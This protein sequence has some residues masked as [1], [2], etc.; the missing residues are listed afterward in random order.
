M[1]RAGYKYI[2]AVFKSRWPIKSSTR[3]VLLSLAWRADPEGLCWPG[4]GWLS[5]VNALSER[6]VQR[7]LRELEAAEVVSTTRKGSRECNP[8]NPHYTN[9]Y[10]INLIGLKRVTERWDKRK[11]ESRT[12]EEQEKFD[13]RIRSLR[14]T[15]QA[16]SL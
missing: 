7:A 10:V 8:R 14:A 6:Q 3:L 13:A 4:M 11:K 12:D 15:Y 5:T 16:A 1:A 2:D 9:R